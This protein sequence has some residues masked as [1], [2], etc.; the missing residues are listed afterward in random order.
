MPTSRARALA[1]PVAL[2]ALT[3]CLA[4]APAASGAA[5]GVQDDRLTSGA[6]ADVP[7][8]I[9]LLRR[10]G[11]RV[12]RLDVLW[13]LVAP[14][15]PDRPTDPGDPAYRWERAD[16][17]MQGFARLGMTPILVA[18]SAPS[19]AAGG[20]G[21]PPGTEVNPNAPSPAD[22]GRFMEA[23]ARRYSGSFTPPGS[24]E[25]LPRARHF[26]IW[27]EPNLG[28]FLSPQVAGGRRVA[29]SRYVAMARAAH[30]AIRRA[31]PRAIVIA[32][33]GG[34]R[35]STGATGTG[36][37]E[38]AR[39]IAAS[40]AP[41]D[42]Y[43][44]HVYP[45]AAPRSG[46]RAF[47]AWGTLTELFAALDAVPRRRGT[48]VYLTEIGY[49]T[50]A[51]PFRDVR[52]SPAQQAAY[53]RQITGLPA[54]RSARVRALIWFNLQDNPNWP[55]GL[56]FEDGR[57][58]PSHA[59]FTRLARASRLT[60]DLR[61]R[62]PVTLSRRQLLINQRIS[63]AAVRRLALVDRRLDD[64]LTRD[65]LRPGGMA[66]PAF[67]PGVSASAASSTAPPPPLGRAPETP[68]APSR[69]PGAAARV[70]LASGQLLINQ[71]VS[72]AAVRRANG[73]EARL[74]AGLSGGDIRPGAIDAARLAPGVTVTQATPPPT[75]APPTATVVAP[76]RRGGGGVRLSVAQLRVNQRI[77][78]AGVRRANALAA[79]L[80]TG[81]SQG[82]FRP[83]SVTAESLDPGLRPG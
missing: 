54:V 76:G 9:D 57:V 41:F 18:Y 77:A 44:Q 24:T 69:R 37:L 23:L 70:R 48:P 2:G 22:Y 58:K 42:A 33:V 43:S 46:T 34:P 49:T 31:N 55:G 79:T 27:N 78:Q 38:W 6:L 51:T 47:P 73:L 28:A 5:L 53:L 72:Q 75:P 62:P 25:P 30:P 21:T 35:S 26:E 65:D 15:R 74:R 40:A 60:A 11:A 1:L 29:V 12:T 67:G 56:R 80:A 8:R 7:G 64:G 52:V 83:G 16:A 20:R 10:S 63:Q 4:T 19:W 81:F 17:A 13:S 66:P 50:A 14:T 68:P 32:G 39:R 3:A 36:A 61:V 71:R 82:D 59:V 45:A